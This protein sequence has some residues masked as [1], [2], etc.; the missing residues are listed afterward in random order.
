MSGQPITQHVIRNVFVCQML[1]IS[2]PLQNDFDLTKPN[3]KYMENTPTESLCDVLC[4]ICDERYKIGEG[5][6][7]PPIQAI[8]R[9]HS[10]NINIITAQELESMTS[11][12]FLNGIMP[13][14]IMR[15]NEER[16]TQQL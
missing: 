15:M 12:D 8:E 14:F 10:S 6:R 9:P 13:Y 2:I 4:P 11:M 7:C 3:E 5:H 16:R 1:G